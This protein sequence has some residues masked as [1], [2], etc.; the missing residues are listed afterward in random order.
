MLEIAMV[1]F[2]RFLQGRKNGGSWSLRLLLKLEPQ[3]TYSKQECREVLWL[4]RWQDPRE[5][6]VAR[7]WRRGKG[8]EPQQCR[9]VGLQENTL[10]RRRCARLGG[11]QTG[12]SPGSCGLRS[13]FRRSNAGGAEIGC[14]YPRNGGCGKVSNSLLVM[15][16]QLYLLTR[17]RQTQDKISESCS[18][19]K[20]VSDK[21]KTKPGTKCT[22]AINS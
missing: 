9:W 15:G 22:P 6:W 3:S 1:A 5:D 14:C 10:S 2:S 17:N 13:F 12:R 8:G 11:G 18:L 7:R 20:Y 16:H 19:L 21:G 4:Q